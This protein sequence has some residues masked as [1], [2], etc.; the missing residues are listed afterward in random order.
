MH[1]RL[2]GHAGEQGRTVLMEA[3]RQGW[4]E[5][6]AAQQGPRHNGSC[7]Q[8]PSPAPTGFCSRFSGA[9]PSLGA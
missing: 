5:L 1:S 9:L 6:Q 2:H 7:A 8:Q 3:W 4:R